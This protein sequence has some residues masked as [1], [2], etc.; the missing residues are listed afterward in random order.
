MRI[1]H[2]LFMLAFAAALGVMIVTAQ[3]QSVAV[4]PYTAA[5]ADAGRGLYQANCA[6]CHGPDLAGRND[7]PQLAGPQF[8]GSWA[9]RT[10]GDLVG[11]MQA[12]MPP[13]NASL[14]EQNYL[15]I[16][17]LI[18]NSNGARPGN[19]PLAASSSVVIRTIATGVVTQVGQAAA[20][21]KQQG[22]QAK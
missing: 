17:A 8:V 12:A 15:N 20:K 7:A 19:Q 13:G 9:S 1:H 10:V 3:Q 16:A 18:L 22:K 6:G 11:F 4:G 14:G 5:Q 2:L 21:G